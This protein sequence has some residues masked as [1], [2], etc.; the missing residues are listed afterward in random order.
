[1]EPKAIERNQFHIIGASKVIE[2]Y[3]ML[4]LVDLFG[5]V[6]YS[7]AF[8]RESKPESKI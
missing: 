2:A 5:D 3:V 8:F 7:E 6:P 1:M 4:T